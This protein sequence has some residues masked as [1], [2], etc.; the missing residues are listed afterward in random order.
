MKARM[1]LNPFQWQS[2]KTRV[3]LFTLA[4]FLISIWSLTF[5]ISRMLRE[6]MQRLLGEQ[7]FST[8]SYIAAEVND[9]LG[10]RLKALEAVAKA[11]APTPLGNVTALQAELEKQTIF[12]SLSPGLRAPRL[13][14][15][16]S[17][18]NGKAPT[19]WTEIWSPPRSRPGSRRSASRSSARI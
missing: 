16:R 4:I 6:D 1:N 18:R 5:Y 7:Q 15:F 11:I 14:L 17:R 10:E 2:L 13:P 12:Q 3:T 9:A 8:V 19:T